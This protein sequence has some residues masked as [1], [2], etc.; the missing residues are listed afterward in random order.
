MASKISHSIIIPTYNRSAQIILA[1][2]SAFQALGSHGEIIVVD[3]NSDTAASKV[4]SHITD[5]R[6]KIIINNHGK[7]AAAARNHGVNCALGSTIFFLD[8]DDRFLP[9]YCQGILKVRNFK[10]EATWGFSAYLLKDN[11]GKETYVK[12]HQTSGI[13]SDSLPLSKRLAGLGMGFWIDRETFLNVGG[14]N[15]SLSIDEDTDLCLRLIISDQPAWFDSTPRVIVARDMASRLTNATPW[16]KTAEAY[17]ENTIRYGG[18]FKALSAN[19]LYLYGRAIRLAAKCSSF[20]LFYQLYR[21][22]HNPLL[23]AYCVLMFF[24]KLL[25]YSFMNRFRVSTH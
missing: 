23:S 13:I 18:H 2:E 5:P 24:I 6:L 10:P 19:S 1:V 4:L 15:Q 20:S 14:L 22:T 3:D 9:D 17:V 11:F 8:D 12:K 25:K 16:R 7:G 21:S